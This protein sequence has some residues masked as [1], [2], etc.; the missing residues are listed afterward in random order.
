M[1]RGAGNRGFTLIEVMVAVAILGSSLLILLETH[2]AALRLFN[3]AR[4]E[5]LMQQFLERVIGEAEVEVL[6]GNL[7]GSGDF[8]KRYPDY[9]YS[10]EATPAGEDEMV[11]L[12]DVTVTVEGPTDSRSMEMFVFSVETFQQ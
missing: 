4:E 8:G 6:A 10:F 12:Y 9:T 11:P 3:D 7:S 5:T 1:K 2:Y